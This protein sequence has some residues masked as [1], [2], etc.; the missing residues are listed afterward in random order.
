MCLVDCAMTY[1]SFVNQSAK[2]EVNEVNH[3]VYTYSSKL[4]VFLFITKLQ[5]M[6]FTE[7]KVLVINYLKRS[8]DYE[9]IFQL[10]SIE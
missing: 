4:G 6:S 5:Q 3:F 10:E 9:N 2:L 7:L 1:H 8:M